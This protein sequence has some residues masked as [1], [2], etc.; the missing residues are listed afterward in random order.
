MACTCD[1][2]GNDQLLKDALGAIN[3]LKAQV[4]RLTESNKL[5]KAAAEQALAERDG[6][7]VAKARAIDLHSAVESAL[8]NPVGL[9]GPR[10]PTSTLFR[11]DA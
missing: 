8:R 4:A 6:D 7:G 11:K 9:Q 1:G 10:P 3:A 5:F 2:N